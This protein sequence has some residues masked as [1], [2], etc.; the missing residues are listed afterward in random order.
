LTLEIN[1]R[2]IS[3]Q[4]SEEGDR[5]RWQF[6]GR[7]EGGVPN[8]VVDEVDVHAEDAL[9]DYGIL[10]IDRGVVLSD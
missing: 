4:A 6:A 10:P 2:A 5:V 9:V 1:G 3:L 7:C 8:V